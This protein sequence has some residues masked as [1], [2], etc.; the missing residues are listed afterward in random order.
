ML[1]S[2]IAVSDGNGC[3]AGS[4]KNHL[5][6]AT[7]AF[8][9]HKQ[10]LGRVMEAIER[11]EKSWALSEEKFRRFRE[12]SAQSRA[13]A[14]ACREAWNCGSLEEMIHRRNRLQQQLQ[15]R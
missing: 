12:Q 13:F 11:L 2:E 9:H 7:L 15:K 6:H 4:D 14:N 3:E 8:Q 1:K 10:H 5:D